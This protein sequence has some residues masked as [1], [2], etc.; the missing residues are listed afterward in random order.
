MGSASTGVAAV[1]S[2]RR[3]IGIECDRGAFD[4]AV[5]RM[6]EEARGAVTDD[7]GQGDTASL[8]DL[9]NR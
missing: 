5:E 3:F 9:A 4:I 6:E 1:R 7:A 2:G 8:I